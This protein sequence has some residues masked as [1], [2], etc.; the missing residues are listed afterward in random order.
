MAAGTLERKLNGSAADRSQLMV[1]LY[2]PAVVAKLC[3]SKNALISMEAALQNS[4]VVTK[5]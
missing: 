2:F 5:I 4:W 1:W 3:S